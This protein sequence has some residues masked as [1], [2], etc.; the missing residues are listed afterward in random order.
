MTYCLQWQSR[1]RKLK[2]GLWY[3]RL[4]CPSSLLISFIISFQ[5]FH[6][7]DSNSKVLGNG[8]GIGVETADSISSVLRKEIEGKISISKPNVSKSFVEGKGSLGDSFV[9]AKGDLLSGNS[10]GISQQDTIPVGMN[11]IKNQAM[12]VDRVTANRKRKNMDLEG[13]S[14]NP[15]QT[16]EM[17]LQIK[18]ARLLDLWVLVWELVCW[19]L[20][21][22]VGLVVWC[23]VLDGFGLS[24]FLWS[25]LFRGTID[26]V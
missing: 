21:F 18:V 23:F 20:F 26:V 3:I 25:W 9:D 15:K 5:P 14:T 24:I 7:E 6:P 19:W 12:E 22:F 16:V 4:I 2:L 8:E 17:I 10:H 11:D 13:K 1:D